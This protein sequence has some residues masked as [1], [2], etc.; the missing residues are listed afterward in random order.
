M[1]NKLVVGVL[2]L[3]LAPPLLGLLAG[4][5]W[6][7]HLEGGASAAW[8]AAG[9]PLEGFVSRHPRAGVN[10]AAR[11]LAELGAPLG[12]DFGEGL[13]QPPATAREAL[14]AL[15]GELNRHAQALLGG[16]ASQPPEAWR[17]FRRAH[18]G[19]LAALVAQ[20]ADGTPPSWEQ[21]VEKDVAA[22]VP[23]LTAH[24]DLAALLV[25]EALEPGP[26]GP[27]PEAALRALVR[28]GAGLRGRPELIS[29]LMSIALD[30]RGLALARRVESAAPA[31]VDEL[32][33]IDARGGLVTSLQSECWLFL[34]YAAREGRLSPT[35]EPRQD[36]WS[37]IGLRLARPFERTFSRLSAADYARVVAGQGGRL[38]RAPLCQ[39]P[40]G[41]SERGLA[42]LA[43]WNGIGRVA[44]PSVSSFSRLT[45]LHAL[46]VELT[47]KVLVLRSQRGA[48]GAWPAQLA[49]PASKTCPGASWTY[50]RRADGSVS[51]AYDGD[52][53]PGE[54][55]DL[56]FEAR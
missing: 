4:P 16:E 13:A 30:R 42:E 48:G 50:A 25:L 24:R 32:T 28:L 3:L 35:P 53:E 23:P 6:A 43:R 14:V 17:A 45:L 39:P 38:A 11:R 29:F 7:A 37:A 40:I 1:R 36:A 10:A 18:A 54:A 8:Q 52:L 44:L 41:E 51:V 46:D 31:T 34:H 2:V 26:H 20:L 19:E 9:L 22:P 5:P 21:D 12:L 56:R 55:D 47:G 49:E 33:R 27:G 15:R